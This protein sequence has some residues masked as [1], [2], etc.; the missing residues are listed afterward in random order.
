[1]ATSH[2][3]LVRLVAAG[4]RIGD[5]GYEHEIFVSYARAPIVGLWVHKFFVPQLQ[6]RANE[7][8]GD[9][10]RIFCDVD[11][12]E[13]VNLP[14]ELKR[15]I[16]ASA[17]LLTVWS[18]DYFRSAWCMAEW[19]SFRRREEMLGL[20]TEANPLGLVYPVRYA[21]GKSFHA[22]AKLALLRK[23]FSELNYSS[24]AFRD[25]AK[26]LKFE[27]LVKEVAD[28]RV[29][30][31]DALPSWRADFPVVEP[32]PMAPASF[33]RPLFDFNFTRSPTTSAISC[34]RWRRQSRL[35]IGR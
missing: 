11:M 34:A 22:D 5:M 28:E 21:D 3:Y 26:Y 10:V 32:Q 1:M 35:K 31:L 13:G 7:I 18:A 24:E 17:L 27:D 15:R 4:N 14:A 25:S 20:F 30:R 23:D 29:D 6:A 19:Q 12:D 33:K 8:A 2:A 16:R 9:V